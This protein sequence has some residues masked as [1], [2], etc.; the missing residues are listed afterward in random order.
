MTLLPRR[1]S[2]DF[3]SDKCLPSDGFPG[4]AFQGKLDG[5]NGIAFCF[6]VRNV[7]QLEGED[8]PGPQIET[9]NSRRDVQN[10]E[11]LIGVKEDFGK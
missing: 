1:K 3:S 5:A 9:R 8:F 4:S 6:L 2:F 7:R 10:T 11:N